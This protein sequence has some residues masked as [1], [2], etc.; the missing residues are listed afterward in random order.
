MVSG[1]QT[2]SVA[3]VNTEPTTESTNTPRPSPTS[4]ADRLTPTPTAIPEDVPITLTFWTVEDVSPLRE[5]ESGA[6]LESKLRLFERA[7]PDIKV[8]LRVK[9]ASGKGGVLDFLRTSRAVAPSVMPDVV[10]MQ[11]TDLDIAFADGFLQPLDG[12][13]DRSIVQD[14]LPAARR[15]GTVNDRLAGVPIGI[16]M[17]HTVYNTRIFTATPILWIDVLTK[18]T[19]YLFPAQGNNGL[20]NDVTLSQYLSVGGKLQDDEG[21]PKIDDRSLQTVLQFYQTSLENQLI[22]ASHLEAATSKELWPLYLKGQTGLTQVSVQQYLTDR[23]ILQNTTFSTLPVADETSVPVGIMHS[24]V[25]VL[26]TDDVDRQ[27]ASL[28]L[29]ESFL[30]TTNNVTWNS[31]NK[32]IPTR[33]TAYQQIAG[34]DPYWLFLTDLLN[35]AQPEPRFSDYDRVGRIMQQSVEQVIRGE[36]LPEEA[37]TNAID[38]LAQ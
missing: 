26:I 5:D 28:R 22:S 20:V 4:N 1:C 35:T 21:N 6:F 3:E 38:A 7:N 32:S 33:D 9:K 14:L 2:A 29:V 18:N 37:A 11:A 23:E 27:D 12:K 24:W 36:A 10:V 16:E 30:S 17:E 13:L 19:T 31:I 25:L 8:D 34:D 15:I